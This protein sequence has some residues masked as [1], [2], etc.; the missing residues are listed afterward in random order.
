[1]ISSPTLLKSVKAGS[2]MQKYTI[3][4]EFKLYIYVLDFKKTTKKNNH[5]LYL[6]KIITTIRQLTIFN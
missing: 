1:M 2:R 3:P 5:V 4:H 6:K